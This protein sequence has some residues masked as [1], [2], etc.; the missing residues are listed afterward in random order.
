MR[1]MARRS[2]A[3]ADC[4]MSIRE[5][6]DGVRIGG[7]R[8]SL[9]VA[10]GIAAALAIAGAAWRPDVPWLHWTMKP[11]ATALL[12]LAALLTRDPLSRSYRGLVTLALCSSLAGDVLLM[13]PEERFL[14]GLGAFLC[15]HVCYAVA[16]T[17]PARFLRHHAGVV[18]F[19]IVATVVLS[20]VLPAVGGTLRLMIVAYVVVITIMAAQ[21]TSWMLDAPGSGSAQLAAIGASL[22]VASDALLAIDRFVAPMPAR[23]L[24]V[25]VPYWFAQGCLAASVQRPPPPT[26]RL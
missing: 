9:L 19:A 1:V 17:I 8:G 26:L 18:A 12:A 10:A 25:L 21:A 5:W 23:D 15:A 4:S 11:A 3:H 7:L 6:G 13:L 20:L 14:A 2:G 22:F 24:L 16:F